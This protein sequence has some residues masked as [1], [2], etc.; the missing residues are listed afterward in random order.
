MVSLVIHSLRIDR[1]RRAVVHQSDIDHQVPNITFIIWYDQ[2][3]MLCTLQVSTMWIRALKLRPDLVSR[4][5]EL[6]Q[7]K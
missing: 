1:D 2:K 6:L 7:E 4:Y 5:Y 3:G